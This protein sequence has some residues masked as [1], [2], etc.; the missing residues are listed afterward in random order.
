MAEEER[1]R[2]EEAITRID[3][4]TKAYDEQWVVRRDDIELTGPEI[5]RGGWATVSVAKFRGAQV[6]V[7][8]IHNQIVSRHNEDLFL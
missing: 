7:K 8:S 4:L 3:L 1:R 5:G 6:A 2:A